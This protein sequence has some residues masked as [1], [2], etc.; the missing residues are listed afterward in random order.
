MNDY[1]THARAFGTVQ[2]RMGDDC[3]VISWADQDFKV[4]PGS[5]IRRKDLN[6]GGFAL[7][8][9]FVFEVLVSAFLNQTFVA[10]N[11]STSTITT[12][13]D[14]KSALLQKPIGYL[15]DTYKADSVEILPGG[16]QLSVECNALNQNS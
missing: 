1:A 12:A 9:D 10:M 15:G 14:L 7:N 11:G 8:A 6:S 5:A 13:R 2:D 4:I 16:F 3:P